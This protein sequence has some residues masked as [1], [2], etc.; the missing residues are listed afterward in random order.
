M[1]RQQI[2]VGYR[3]ADIFGKGTIDGIANGSPVQAE[4]A[5]PYTA[6][7]TMSAEKRRING[8]AGTKRAEINPAP[9]GISLDV[10]AKRDNFTSE[11]VS[12]YDGIG[13]GREFTL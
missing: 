2:S 11:F 3:N 4:I 7:G 10:F 6:E 13:S 5:A 9:T 12:G 1:V 8:N